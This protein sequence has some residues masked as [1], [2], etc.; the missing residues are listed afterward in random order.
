MTGLDEID[1]ARTPMGSDLEQGLRTLA[2]D[3]KIAF[4]LYGRVIL[5]VPNRP[6]HC[7]VAI[8]V[9]VVT[10]PVMVT[11]VLPVLPGVSVHAEPSPIMTWVVLTVPAGSAGAEPSDT[12]GVDSFP[13]T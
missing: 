3:Q 5:P 4:K 2:L 13:L 6:V 8:A 1:G 12:A 9:A 7:A 11:S 10:R